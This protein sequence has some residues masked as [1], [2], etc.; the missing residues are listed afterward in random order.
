MSAALHLAKPEH[1]EKLLPMVETFHSY[2]QIDQSDA[3][4]RAGLMPLLEGSPL[5]AVYLIGPTVAPIGYIVVCFGWSLEYGG[6]DGFIDEFFIRENI[7]GRGIGS[8]VLA[9][10]AKALAGA[11]V[12]ALHFEVDRDDTKLHGFYKRA[13]F[14]PRERYFLMSRT[15]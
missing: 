11:D 7:R 6:I 14:E 1:L 3:M 2:H 9:S 15:L 12:K 10:L 13:G 5:G 4:R 8:E